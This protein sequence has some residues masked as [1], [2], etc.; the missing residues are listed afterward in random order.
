MPIDFFMHE[1]FGH[2]VRDSL[3]VLWLLATTMGELDKVSLAKDS[4]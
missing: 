4:D 2:F 1:T 3:T